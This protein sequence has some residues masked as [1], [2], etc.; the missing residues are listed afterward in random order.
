MTVIATVLIPA[1][2]AEGVTTTQYIATNV[3]AL[4]D[5]FTA[6]NFS[7]ASTQITVYLVTSGDTPG[8]QNAIVKARTL[9]AGE[10]YIFPEIVGSAI[11][12]SGYISTLCGDGASVAIRAS[13]REI[14]S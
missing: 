4:I 2:I 10:T 11:L 14:S 6:T 7:G 5:K 9:A 12:A 1:K 13:G 8:D 3:T